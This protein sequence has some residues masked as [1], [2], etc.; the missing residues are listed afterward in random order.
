MK[1]IKTLACAIAISSTAPTLQAEPQTALTL[2][3]TYGQ[4][5]LRLGVAAGLAY[6]T[7]NNLNYDNCTKLARKFF[8]ATVG[9]N[10]KLTQEK[11]NEQRAKFE[12]GIRQNKDQ[13]E[14]GIA[15][16]KPTLGVVLAMVYLGI[17]RLTVG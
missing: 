5:W 9:A 10:G 11:V 7:V 2:A 13:I 17:L 4:S 8:E 12:A 14:L 15:I 3:V 1:L 6:A 16:G